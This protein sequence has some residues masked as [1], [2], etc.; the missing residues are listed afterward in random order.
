VPLIYLGYS[1][2]EVT[3]TLP[4]VTY[5]TAFP[6]GKRTYA[7]SVSVNRANHPNDTLFFWGVE[8]VKGSLTAPAGAREDEPWLIWLN[9]GYAIFHP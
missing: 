5:S 8:S 7:G 1:D 3:D 6:N 9:G 4:N 2:F